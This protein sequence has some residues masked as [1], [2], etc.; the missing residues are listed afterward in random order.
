M[1]MPEQVGRWPSQDF[2]DR[3][4]SFALIAVLTRR[5]PEDYDM[6]NL[7]TQRRWDLGSEVGSRLED[8]VNAAVKE[9]LASQA[10]PMF[11][12]THYQV[13]P[14]AEGFAPH[15]IITIWEHREQ[16]AQTLAVLADVWAV[17]EIARR[18]KERLDSWIES[19]DQGLEVALS[20]PPE[21]L[22]QLCL[23]H[24]RTTYHPRATLQSDWHVLREDF[25]AGYFSPAH[26]SE[27]LEYAVTVSTRDRTYLYRLN[28][29]GE[30]AAHNVR[31]GKQVT[32]LPLPDLFEAPVRSP[33]VPSLAEQSQT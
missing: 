13:G 24:V 8:A 10:A 23:H 25:M 14:A 21:V 2:V 31:K 29:T 9:V 18:V 17:A 6:D 12:R 5:S 1:S 33:A 7:P 20:F 28:G 32:A 19:E 22:K 16:V 30:V 26:P 11:S 27:L 3:S 4:E 15:W